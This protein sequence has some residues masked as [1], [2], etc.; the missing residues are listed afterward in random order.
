MLLLSLLLSAVEMHGQQPLEDLRTFDYAIADSLALNF[1][2]AKYK[3]SA[4]IV[5][6]LIASLQTEHERV[7]VIYRWITD[8]ITYSFSNR[9]S[10]PNKVLKKRKAVCAGYAALFKE[11]LNNAG[12]TSEIVVGYTKTEIKDIG[13]KLERPDHA[14]NAV[15]I[16][17]EWYLIDVTWASGHR[18]VKSRKFIKQHDELYFLSPPELFVKKHLPEEERWQ[19]LPE[20]VK[21]RDFIR[22]PIYYSEWLKCD[23]RDIMPQKGVIRLRMKDTLSFHINSACALDDICLMLGDKR[24][25][26]QPVIE[27]QGDDYLIKHKFNRSGKYTLVLFANRWSIVAYQINIRGDRF[28]R[29]L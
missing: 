28:K 5:G 3:S 10:D 24:S 20:P 1:P 23:Y 6:P 9:T 4:E 2:K 19:L 26:Y 25:I 27:K 14:W 7:R 16:N 12:I 22:A 18:D 29:H 8:N 21:K 11:M 13:K 17:Q 15:R